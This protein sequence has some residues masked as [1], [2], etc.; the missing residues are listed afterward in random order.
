MTQI[1]DSVQLWDCDISDFDC[2]QA[3]DMAL[4]KYKPIVSDISDDESQ[5]SKPSFD[6]GFTVDS[7][8]DQEINYI[9]QLPRYDPPAK[10]H[11]FGWTCRPRVD[12]YH[13]SMPPPP[14]APTSV[15][16]PPI[17]HQFKVPSPAETSK[18]V[19]HVKP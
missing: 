11:K 13:V 8:S 9:V 1:E 18:P 3:L 19:S 6:L 16:S 4:E 2:V 12:H 15:V 14:P 17:E 10:C 5:Q 7:D